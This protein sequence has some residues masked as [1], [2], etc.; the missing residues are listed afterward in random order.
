LILFSP[1]R[2]FNSTYMYYNAQQY[3]LNCVI[4]IESLLYLLLNHMSPI[5]PINIFIGTCKKP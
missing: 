4:Y 3:T 1:S 2:G 5:Q